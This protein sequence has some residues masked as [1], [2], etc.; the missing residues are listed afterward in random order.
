MD[1]VTEP[2]D[3]LGQIT[4]GLEHYRIETDMCQKKPCDDNVPE[5]NGNDKHRN[6]DIPEK[7]GIVKQCG[8]DVPVENSH[9]VTG[10][11]RE[12][13]NLIPKE[14][15][16]VVDDDVHD[17]VGSCMNGE[18]VQSEHWCDFHLNEINIIL[19]QTPMSDVKPRMTCNVDS[20]QPACCNFDSER[21]DTEKTLESVIRHS[22]K[23][24]NLPLLMEIKLSEESQSD[25]NFG[26]EFE[27]S[28]SAHNSFNESESH[29]ILINGNGSAEYV[30]YPKLEEVDHVAVKNET[31]KQLQN[32][33]GEIYDAETGDIVCA[34]TMKAQSKLDAE[35]HEEDLD[36][37]ASSG[38]Q[39]I[40][41][42]ST[43]S[44][45]NSSD[46]TGVRWTS[47]PSFGR[48]SGILIKNILS[49]LSYN[50]EPQLVPP[51]VN[52]GMA[53][54]VHATCQ[55]GDSQSVRPDNIVDLDRLAA[56]IQMA[57][58]ISI[59]IQGV[60]I[61]PVD[62]K[63]GGDWMVEKVQ[64]QPMDRLT[65]TIT[66]GICRHRDGNEFGES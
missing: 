16:V 61:G 59:D 26:S 25:T 27:H 18:A 11:V 9:I 7:N 63:A 57:A 39:M 47:T 43:P 42:S 33:D 45:T 58:D 4:R 34:N 8:D 6:T 28:I 2:I 52:S 56:G 50:E 37:R 54:V 20:F 55:P 22:T 53:T 14:I 44:N 64:L 62:R 36:G 17:D 38:V 31:T 29:L 23:L 30:N 49:P 60:D 40:G 5:H 35:L 13:V 41:S 65:E 66:S 24:Q 21:Y 10:K 15:A 1:L 51:D 46:K 19:G 12:E 48:D 32:A 3:E